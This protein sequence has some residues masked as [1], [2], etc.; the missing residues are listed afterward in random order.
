M[1]SGESIILE[2]LGA[3]SADKPP[4][5]HAISRK[6]TSHT[7]PVTEKPPAGAAQQAAD[8]PCSAAAA[9]PPAAALRSNIVPTLCTL[10]GLCSGRRWAVH[11]LASHTLGDLLRQPDAAEAQVLWDDGGRLL[12]YQLL[13][14]LVELHGAGTSHGRLTP[15][16][17]PLTRDGCAF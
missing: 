12:L 7:E 5:A 2:W 14:G 16:H 13:S 9:K 17:L 4:A 11:A 3:A 1:S 6:E 15:E 10:E 8:A